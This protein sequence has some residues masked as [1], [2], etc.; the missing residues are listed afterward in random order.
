LLLKNMGLIQKLLD[1]FTKKEFPVTSLSK[2]NDYTFTVK[3]DKYLDQ[4]FGWTYKAAKTKAQAVA[5][6][7]QTLYQNSDK[8]VEVDND[9]LLE[10]LK[11]FNPYQT[12]YQ[13]RFITHVQLALAGASFWYMVESENGDHVKEFYI[14][15]PEQMRIKP[16]EIGL[17]KAYTYKDSKGVEHDLDPQDIIAFID[18]DP[19]NWLE[20]MSPLQASRFQHNTS[21]F[22]LRWNMNF[23][24]NNAQPEGFLVSEGLSEDNRKA[25]EQQLKAKYGGPDNAGRVGVLN[26]ALDWLPITK[27]Q[28]DMEYIEGL[29][30]MRDDILSIQGVPKPLVGLTDSKYNNMQEAQRIFQQYTV[31]PSLTMEREVLNEQLIRKYYKATDRGS[32]RG[33][34]YDYADPVEMDVEKN[35]KASATLFQANVID[36]ATAKEMVGVDQ[37]EEDEGLYYSDATRQPVAAPDLT[38]D[39]K[40]IED[41]MHLKLH[42]LENKINDIPS[43]KEVEKQRREKLRKYFHKKSIEDENIFKNKLQ[44]FWVSQQAR[45]MQG[46]KSAK[47][48][49]SDIEFDKGAEIKFTIEFFAD[50]WD[51]LARNYNN[52]AS[53]LTGSP[54]KLSEEDLQ[55]MRKQLEYFATEI[56]ETTQ[57]DLLDILDEAIEESRSESEVAEDIQALYEG[58]A[59]SRSDTIARTEINKIK[60]NVMR[61]NYESNEFTR[62]VEWLSAQDVDVRDAHQRADGQ[63]RPKGESFSVGGEKLKYPGDPSGSAEN[64]INCR[65]TL[66]PVIE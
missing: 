22:G 2:W 9:P 34:Y 15:S 35:S 7:K 33:Y 5:S 46:I 44:G 66:L 26:A 8:P 3:S 28:R 56:N 41:R 10:D 17:P 4:Y 60:N 51:E 61:A 21:E 11:A 12:L 36:R 14:L 38:E 30:M 16:D 63:V 48:Q 64:V 31:V 55:E 50:V 53:D 43:V 25:I 29:K 49:I 39:V 20:G 57:K 6:V 24:G 37:I 45:V 18:P 13:A 42:A 59:G 52:V 32:D 1:P 40:A 19:K 27:S 23:F 65:C 47:K 62:G 54:Y 58:F